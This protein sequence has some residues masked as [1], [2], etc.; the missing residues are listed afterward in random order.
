MIRKSIQR[1]FPVTELQS[2]LAKAQAKMTEAYVDAML[3]T[4][5]ENVEYFTGMGS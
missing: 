5:E 4:N 1:G 3:L 2:R